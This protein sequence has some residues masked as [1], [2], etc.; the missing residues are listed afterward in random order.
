[1]HQLIHDTKRLVLENQKILEEDPLQLYS[2]V[3]F[4]PKTNVLKDKI[5]KDSG[6][7]VITTAPKDCWNPLLHTLEGHTNWVKTVTFSPNGEFVASGSDDGTIR[8]WDTESGVECARLPHSSSV[9]GI[10]FADKGEHIVSISGDHTIK[11]WKTVTGS[12]DM[13]FSNFRAGETSTNS[14]AFSWERKLIAYASNKYEIKICSESGPEIVSLEGHT[15]YISAVVWSPHE[16]KLLLA[17]ASGD[18]TVRI[19]NIPGSDGQYEDGVKPLKT[20]LDLHSDPVNSVVF[21]PVDEN[22][23]ASGSDDHTIIIWDL[24]L[25]DNEQARS[26]LCG[27][28]GPVNSVAFSLD[29]QLVASGSDDGTVRLWNVKLGI[30]YGILEGHSSWVRAVSFSSNGQLASAS[31]DQTVKIWDVEMGKAQRARN[32]HSDYVTTVAFSPQLSP[33]AQ[34]QNWYASASYDKTV[35]LWDTET[36]EPF[37]TLEGHLDIINCVVFSQDGGLIASA[38]DDQTINSWNTESLRQAREDTGSVAREADFIFEGHQGRL[39]CIA[40]S[41]DS[42]FII[43]SSSDENVMLWDIERV[44]NQNKDKE[45]QKLNKD[46]TD[47]PQEVEKDE[48][49]DKGKIIIKHEETV[50]M[51]AV[52]L[53]AASG[54]LLIAS[55]SN[56]KEVGLWRLPKGAEISTASE[57]I[58]L[59]G[60]NDW[61]R[62][63]AFSHNGAQLASG[64]D[65]G[66]VKVWTTAIVQSACFTLTGHTDWIKSLAFSSNDK[67]LVSGSDDSRIRLWDTSNWDKEAIVL[68]GHD[69]AV[70]SIAIS[71]PDNK[72]IVSASS[73]MTV[74]IWDIQSRT[75]SILGKHSDRVSR[76]V[77][78]P[79]GYKIVSASD[80]KT[81]KLWDTDKR[82]LFAA[83]DHSRPITQI[84][85]SKNLIATIS[86]Q[87][88]IRLWDLTA[89]LQRTLIGHSGNVNCISFSEDGELL[90]SGSDD[91]SVMVWSRMTGQRT[92]TLL[93]PGRV[94]LV[95]FLGDKIATAYRESA[96]EGYVYKVSLWEVGKEVLYLTSE[97]H[98]RPI[99]AVDILLSKKLPVVATASEDNKIRIWYEETTGNPEVLDADGPIKKLHFSQDSSYLI[100]N[101]GC[102]R[103]ARLPSAKPGTNPPLDPTSKLYVEQK[104]VTRDV[105]KTKIFAIPDEYQ[106]TQVCVHNEVVI[107]GHKS[108]TIS[109]LTFDLSKISELGSQGYGFSR[110]ISSKSSESGSSGGRRSE[111]RG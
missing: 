93:L 32:Q 61:V 24:G 95:T 39:T 86:G 58:K 65:D 94:N 80:D 20:T 75:G 96:G 68:V 35:K 56:D 21:S 53:D 19:W 79:D 98:T 74:R 55:A 22:I 13:G 15:S 16:H 77:F 6:V 67:L 66:K 73:D 38:S 31:D 2:F 40:F 9:Y 100:T 57:A 23:L 59:T 17:S 7:R 101:R 76:A 8:L 97:S 45:L 87:K 52:S 70:N 110:A 4:S 109:I 85:F 26:R 78:S 48:N 33:P 14:I 43:S 11:F 28:T 37:A 90:A 92:W 71:P 99:T 12:E 47:M 36:G 18:E 3:L 84:E 103:T 104:W 42:K 88:D 82:Q 105:T 5:Q 111:T 69:R 34:S 83:P 107:L 106:P 81:V 102:I 50:R 54:D 91:K 25:K 60:H 108:G 63:I 29:G 49:K 62:A 64:S 1:M 41:P 51:V 27:H 44:R 30:P 10:T 89:K 46:K 72:L